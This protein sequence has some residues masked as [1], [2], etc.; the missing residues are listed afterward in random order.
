MADNQLSAANL[1]LPHRP[2][3]F[4]AR[5]NPPFT[6]PLTGELVTFASLPPPKEFDHLYQDQTL[7]SVKES[8]A[9][10]TASELR[11][12]PPSEPYKIALVQRGGCDFAT[13]VRAAQERGAAGV[14]VGDMISHPGETEEE[15]REREAL[16][17]MFSPGTFVSRLLMVGITNIHKRILRTSLFPRYS[18]RELRIS[19]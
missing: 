1:T 19:S 18:F 15:G 11:W 7:D 14:I 6:L 10:I 16:I 3:A 2:A 17:T 5:T 13:K 4:P 8:Q 12:T 9:C